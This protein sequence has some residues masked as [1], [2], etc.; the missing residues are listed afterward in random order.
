KLRQILINLLNN[1]IKF[2]QKGSISVEIKPENM[3]TKN[4]NNQINL[5]FIV[6]DTGEGIAEEEMSNLFQVFSQTSTEKNAHEGTGLGLAISKKFVE[7]ME[8]DIR[9]KSQVGTGTSFSLTIP[10]IL[11]N[12]AQVEIRLNQAPIMGLEP[13]QPSYKILIVDDQYH[14][15][16]LLIKMLKPLGFLLQEASNGEE[17]IALYQIWQPD[18]IFMDLKMPF[19]DGYAATKQI[20]TLS[21]NHEKSPIIIAI[22]ASVLEE[23]QAEILNLGCDDFIRKPFPETTIFNSLQKHLGLRY[24]YGEITPQTQTISPDNLISADLDI[25]PEKWR[26]Q[27]NYAVQIGDIMIMLQLLDEIRPE[28][29]DLAKALGCLIDNYEYNKLLDLIHNS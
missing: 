25:L 7:L 23:E 4:D 18:V 9:V 6:T 28:H 29:E 17:A 20:K 19:L 21:E 15:R 24:I 22:S 5:T 14:N 8:G 11:V 2:T 1:A 3:P 16:L 12:S 27:L 10:V 26:S 13:D